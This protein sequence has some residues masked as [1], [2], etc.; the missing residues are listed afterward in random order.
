M[1]RGRPKKSI[2]A[3]SAASN[4]NVEA[5]STCSASSRPVR[6][7]I[8]VRKFGTA[9]ASEQEFLDDPSPSPA[10]MRQ[11]NQKSTPKQSGSGYVMIHKSFWNNVCSSLACS[12]CRQKSV[13]MKT[14]KLSGLACKLIMYCTACGVVLS[15]VTSSPEG[16]AGSNPHAN[17]DYEVNRRFVNFFVS[18]GKTYDDVVVFSNTMGI[19]C[20]SKAMF[21]KYSQE[22]LATENLH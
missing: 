1:P 20:I 22:V 5:A 2:V 8:A 4:H 10:A 7:R 9:S 14:E 13:Q 21:E 19:P 6:N 17:P 3:S 16:H 18:E 11:L 15:Q 12:S